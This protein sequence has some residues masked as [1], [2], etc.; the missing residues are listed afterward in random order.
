[1]VDQKAPPKKQGDKQGLHGW[2]A[3]LAVFGCGTLAAFGAFG[4]VVAILGTFIST[5]SSGFGSEEQGSDAVDS[6]AARPTAPR[7][8]FLAEKFDL[9]EI[10][11]SIS[12]I[13]LSMTSGSEEP[14][15]ESIDGGPP[16]EDNLVRSGSCGGIVRPESTYTVPWEF[17]FSYRAVIYSPNEDRDELAQADL[18]D[19]VEEI[20]SS[21]LTI[22]ESGSYPMV[23]EAHY[24]YGAP[25]SGVGNFYTV[26]ARKRSG[27][28]M[29]SLTSEDGASPEEFSYEVMK[30]EAR[31]D[32]DLGSMI[33]R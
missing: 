9:C 3:A 8:E 11:D 1:M 17:E 7:D 32:N 6:I 5:F 4:V 19:W 28:F 30:L 27:V 18:Q 23:D 16:A 26:V 31:L 33:P 21:G 13:Q 20:E 2:K 24:F 25:E 10:I 29:V 22:E 12:A 15:D 14:Q